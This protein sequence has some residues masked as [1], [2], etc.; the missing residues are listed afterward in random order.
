MLVTN[1][2]RTVF[3]PAISHIEISSKS[4]NCMIPKA[5]YTGVSQ[6]WLVRLVIASF[7]Q[8]LIP[9]PCFRKSKAI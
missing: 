8:V 6:V 5:I 1:Y 4:G 7:Q 9:Y 3:N 2:G